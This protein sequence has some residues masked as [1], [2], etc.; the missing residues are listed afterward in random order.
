M[1]HDSGA[2]ADFGGKPCALSIPVG[3]STWETST[4]FFDPGGIVHRPPGL[5]RN[6]SSI[7]ASRGIKKILGS[8]RIYNWVPIHAK[9]LETSKRIGTIEGWQ[10]NNGNY[11]MRT[12][13]Y[14]DA[15]LVHS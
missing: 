12:L 15:D 13:H 10:E 8:S 7:L 1:F 9:S 2:A 5:L 14:F 3:S 11:N 4:R 6:F